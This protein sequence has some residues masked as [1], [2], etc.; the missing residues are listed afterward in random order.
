MADKPTQESS[1]ND[2]ASAP[3]NGKTPAKT[4][5]G[6][7]IKPSET[8]A[9]HAEEDAPPKKKRHVVRTI[10]IIAIIVVVLAIAVLAFFIY[11]GV[12]APGDAAAKY[13]IMSYIQEDEVT[14]YVDTY[15]TQMGYGESDEDW[16]EFLG[17]NGLTPDLMRQATIRQLIIDRMVERKAANLGLSVDETELDEYIDTMKNE[18]AFGSDTIWEETLEM[19]GRTEDEVRDTYAHT[20]LE[21]ELFQAEVPTPPVTDDEIFDYLVSYYPTGLKTKHIYYFTMAAEGDETGLEV[22]GNVQDIQK[23]LASQDDLTAEDFASYVTMFSSD[24]DLVARGGANG[25]SV[26]ISDYS[27]NYQTAVSKTKKGQL[28]DVF[29]EETDDGSE[30]YSFIWVDDVVKLPDVSEEDTDEIDRTEYLSVLP[31]TLKS[32]FSDCTAQI[33]WNSDCQDYLETLYEDSKPIIYPLSYIP[34]YY[35][36][37]TGVTVTAQGT[38]EEYT[39]ED[40]GIEDSE[41]DEADSEESDAT[42][43]DAS[44]NESQESEDNSEG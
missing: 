7:Q 10:V 40:F 17:D 24:E 34:D 22:M 4:D 5:K 1:A 12:L 3:S 15:R 25:W 37:M 13:D 16:A 43:E 31:D 30:A 39:A 23:M 36:D 21:N 32:Y 19:Y 41:T 18:M 28:S 38:G 33:K 42:E 44:S 9:S 14:E 2:K 6:S 8:P 27:E 26:D 29:Y 35:V 20:L 11:R